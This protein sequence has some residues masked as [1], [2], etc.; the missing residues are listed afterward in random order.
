MWALCNA[1]NEPDTLLLQT[2]LHS[3]YFIRGLV[4]FLVRNNFKNSR[5]LV[6]WELS[7]L[8]KQGLM[9]YEE[10]DAGLLVDKHLSFLRMNS[11]AINKVNTQIETF[12]DIESNI[13]I[14]L[15]WNSNSTVPALNSYRKASIMSYQSIRIG[16]PDSTV[17]FFWRQLLSLDMIKETILKYKEAEDKDDLKYNSGRYAL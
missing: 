17:S 6:L 5:N 15:S 1:Q 12:F 13:T 4:K 14:K 11:Q 3:D 2:E 16:N 8:I 9:I 7:K 10:I